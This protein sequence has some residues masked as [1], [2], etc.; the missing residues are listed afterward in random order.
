MEMTFT[1]YI[2]KVRIEAS[3]KLLIGTNKSIW[4]I[5]NDTGYGDVRSFREHFKEIYNVTPL[6]FRK[7]LGHYMK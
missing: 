1:G 4:E 2:R 3:C 6:K 7:M 5:A